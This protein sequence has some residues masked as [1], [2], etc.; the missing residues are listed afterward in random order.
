[1]TDN[2]PLIVITGPTA[3]GKTRR[4]VELARHL[5]DA[6]IISADSRQ[7]YRGMDIGTG[8]DIEE[9]GEIPVHLIDICPAG[10]KYNLYEYLRD[11][12]RAEADIRSRGRRPILCGGTGLYVESI[13]KGLALPEVPENP[14]LRLSLKGKSLDELAAILAGMKQLHNVTDID[15]CQRAIRAIE[16]Q[17]YYQQHPEAAAQATPKPLTDALVIGVDVDRDTRRRRITER[18]KA[19]LDSGM[20]DE[21]RRLLDSGIAPDDLIYYGLEYKYLTLYVTGQLNREE[22]FSQLEIAIHQFAKRQMTWFRNM[23]G[24]TGLPIHWLSA[25]LTPAEF[26][27]AVTALL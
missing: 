1:M 23:P 24:R 10:Y 18:L 3:S 21:V 11:Y 2:R 13:L 4:A 27:A 20:A 16:I 8:K 15:T 26:N 19:R 9:Y 22:M 14:Q 17:T 5:G 12:R 7:V 6:E 25:S